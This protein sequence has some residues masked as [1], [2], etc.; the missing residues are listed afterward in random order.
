MI[1]RN[2]VSKLRRTSKVQGLRVFGRVKCKQW[3]AC[4]NCNKFF[5][6]LRILFDILQFF[7]LQK[8]SSKLACVVSMCCFEHL[9]ALYYYF[10]K[11]ASVFCIWE[12]SKQHLLFCPFLCWFLSFP[13]STN[14]NNT[15]NL[16]LVKL[17]NLNASSM[18]N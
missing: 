18:E 17:L 13:A 11:N 9:F 14:L 10:L 4:S 3:V 2:D 1:L 16:S 5:S 15:N 12:S 8:G 7:Y 6:L